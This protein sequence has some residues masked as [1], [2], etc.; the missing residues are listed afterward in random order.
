MMAFEEYLN[1]GCPVDFR[2]RIFGCDRETALPL[3]P[4]VFRNNLSTFLATDEAELAGFR[5]DIGLHGHDHTGWA[6]YARLRF[7]I[8]VQASASKSVLLPVYEE[9]VAW[10]ENLN[11]GLNRRTYPS[12][13]VKM[14]SPVWLRIITEDTLVASSLSSFAIS[15][16]IVVSSVFAF[17]QNVFISLFSI[18]T[19]LLLVM[20]LFGFIISILEWEFGAIQAVGLTAF[21]GISVD[22]VLH[23]AHAFH[24]SEERTRRF[25]VKNALLNLG[26]SIFGGALTTAGATVFLFPT[27]IYLFHQLGVMLFLNTLIALF[28]T[29]FFLTPLLDAIGPVG[30]G[31]Q[32]GDIFCFCRR[33]AEDTEETAGGKDEPA[34]RDG[35]GHGPRAAAMCP[36]ASQDEASPPWECP[37]CG[38]AN[39]GSRPCCNVCSL[40]APSAAAAGSCDT[41]QAADPEGG[42]P[43]PASQEEAARPASEAECISEEVLLF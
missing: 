13:E 36:V 27:W 41:A 6:A 19:I 39:R 23:L 12:L 2:A 20:V 8:N 35:V 26:S 17:T 38:E 42:S 32:S 22:Y 31:L 5:D 21:V 16:A 18:L 30:H 43:M 1:V 25:K 3:A 14:V 9:W 33:R 34:M 29:F 11:L 4:A 37:S 28:F 24:Q 10:V 40:Q 7:K 15:I